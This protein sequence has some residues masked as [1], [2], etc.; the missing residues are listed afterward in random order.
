MI[1]F[2]GCF[3]SSSE[4][5]VVFIESLYEDGSILFFIKGDDAGGERYFL[6]CFCG[7]GKCIY[8]PFGNVILIIYDDEESVTIYDDDASSSFGEYFVGI[9]EHV[10]EI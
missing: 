5:N 3:S 6:A 7:N 9:D 1:L 2:I 4:T 8:S 10:V